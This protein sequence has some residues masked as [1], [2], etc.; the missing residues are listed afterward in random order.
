MIKKEA[1][2]KRIFYHYAYFLLFAAII[3]KLLHIIAHYLMPAETHSFSISIISV[4]VYYLIFLISLF[5][6]RKT[7]RARAGAYSGKSNAICISVGIAAVFMTYLSSYYAVYLPGQSHLVRE[8]SDGF[9]YL[10]NEPARGVFATRKSGYFRKCKYTRPDNKPAILLVGD[11]FVYGSRIGISDTLCTTIGDSLASR[12]IAH[13]NILNVAIPGIG[14]SSAI[15]LADYYISKRPAGWI[16]IGYSSSNSFRKL[17]TLKRVRLLKD[18]KSYQILSALLGVDIVSFAGQWYWNVRVRPKPELSEHDYRLFEKLVGS[19]HIIIISYTD[20]DPF[21]S[22][23]TQKYKEIDVV[24]F[25]L[26]ERGRADPALLVPNDAH[27]TGKA[28]RIIGAM[29]AERIASIK[30]K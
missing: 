17:D 19:S 29:I 25:D 27:P 21:L 11:S 5:Y 14:L 15:G 18:D 24:Y 8:S 13:P 7:N 1:I 9:I 28:N 6:Y 26:D 4:L 2:V 22:R 3:R 30:K 23:L 16:V 20:P 12:N 10:I